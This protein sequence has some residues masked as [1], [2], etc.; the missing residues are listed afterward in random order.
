MVGPARLGCRPSRSGYAGFGASL[1][2]RRVRRGQSGYQDV[3]Y[4]LVGALH[5]AADPSGP[6]CGAKGFTTRP[7][8]TWRVG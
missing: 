6:A 5:S 7:A 8:Q 4:I 3:A 1:E 2:R